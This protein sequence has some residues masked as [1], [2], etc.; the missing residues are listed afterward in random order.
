MLPRRG[1]HRQERSLRRQTGR[2]MSRRRKKEDEERRNR[3][4]LRIESSAQIA[5]LAGPR[6]PVAVDTPA[7]LS[8]L[9]I[10]G[11]NTKP[12]AACDKLKAI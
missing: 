7:N 1:N 9:T 8:T 10:H 6:S 12:T 3:I 11:L 2:L 5:V 4:L